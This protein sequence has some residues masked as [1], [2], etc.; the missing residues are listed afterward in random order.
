MDLHKAFVFVFMS[1]VHTP[2]NA[3]TKTSGLTPC[4]L[5]STRALLLQLQCLCVPRGLQPLESCL[6]RR[7]SGWGAGWCTWA[8]V[9]AGSASMLPS[10]LLPLTAALLIDAAP[11]AAAAVVAGTV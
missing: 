10:M 5:E 8:W 4:S 9:V 11:A 1:Y 7:S 3:K 6:H 2:F